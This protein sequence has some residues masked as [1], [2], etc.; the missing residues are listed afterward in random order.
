MLR[1]SRL[2]QIHTFSNHSTFGRSNLRILLRNFILEIFMYRKL[3]LPNFIGIRH[4][5]D[6]HEAKYIRTNVAVS[7]ALRY[8]RDVRVSLDAGPK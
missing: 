2:H 3:F 4:L 8:F 6:E 7:R 1:A 5:Y